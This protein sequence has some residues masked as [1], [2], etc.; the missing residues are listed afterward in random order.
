[1]TCVLRLTSEGDVF[2]LRRHGLGDEQQEDGE[3][4]QHRDAHVHLLAGL[5]WQVEDH[6][7]RA[8]DEDAGQH[9]VEEVV[10]RPPLQHDPE[11]H[12]REHPG[13]VVLL[14]GD[15]KRGEGKHFFFVLKENAE[16]DYTRNADRIQDWNFEVSESPL[17]VETD[18]VSEYWHGHQVPLSIRCEVLQVPFAGCVD[19]VHHI[20]G[21]SP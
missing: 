20:D 8:R 9:Q 1:M 10:E 13:R 12:V 3:G 11:G 6:E 17:A 5:G 7:R 2:G 16:T 14:W 19:D 18:L 4:E 15:A 21:I